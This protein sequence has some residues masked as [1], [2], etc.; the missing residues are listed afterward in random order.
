MLHGEL[1][2]RSLLL[3]A[4]TATPLPL[5]NLSTP[6][7]EGLISS[8]LIK[9]ND[10]HIANVSAK[11][12]TGSAARPRHL[13]SSWTNM[14]NICVVLNPLLVSLSFYNSAKVRP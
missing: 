3:F 4:L 13:G 14:A 9:A 11:A 2:S 8:S 6:Q 5:P 1:Q 10:V 7:I 12:S